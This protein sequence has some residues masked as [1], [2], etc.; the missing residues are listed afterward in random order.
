MWLLK[1]GRQFGRFPEEVE[2]AS[3][4]LLRHLTIEEWYL[5]AVAERGER[6]GT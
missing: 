4:S 6:G 1:I 5:Q 2:Q 3:Q